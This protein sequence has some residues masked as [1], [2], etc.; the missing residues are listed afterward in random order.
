[1]LN[2]LRESSSQ[3]KAFSGIQRGVSQGRGSTDSDSIGVDDQ[4]QERPLRAAVDPAIGPARDEIGLD[5]QT[6]SSSIASDPEYGP[7]TER[8]PALSVSRN[9][10]GQRSSRLAGR[11]DHQAIPIQAQGKIKPGYFHWA[12][13]PVDGQI[14]Q[15]FRPRHAGQVA[16]ASQPPVDRPVRPDTAR[17]K[18][19]S[20]G[21]Q[22]CRRSK[23][24]PDRAHRQSAP[25]FQSS[26]PRPGPEPRSPRSARARL[27]APV[28]AG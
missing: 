22:G 8:L 24:R 17:G 11:L 12:L 7:P 16:A 14:A 21:S 6:W 5:E 3:F 4:V 2:P 27:A 19:S 15:V 28:R 9:K 18:S 10:S 20:A 1:M 25:S 23:A 26:G 13:R